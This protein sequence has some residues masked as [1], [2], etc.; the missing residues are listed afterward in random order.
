MYHNGTTKSSPHALPGGS[1]IGKIQSRSVRQCNGEPATSLY[2]QPCQIMIGTTTTP[3]NHSGGSK[4]RVRLANTRHGRPGERSS[5]AATN[6]PASANMIPIEG[7]SA[8]S[9]TQPKMW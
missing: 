9:Q 1:E 7:K 5:E 8:G 3:I 4:R 2:V 6:E